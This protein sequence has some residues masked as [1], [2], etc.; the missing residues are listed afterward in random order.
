MSDHR[1]FPEVADGRPSL[2]MEPELWAAGLSLTDA[3]F[4][5]RQLAQNGYVLIEA[6]ALEH[7]RTEN[8]WLRAEN[9]S[10]RLLLQSIIDLGGTMGSNLYAD[11]VDRAC[12][13]ALKTKGQDDE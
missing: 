9:Q 1:S 13:A 3:R 2:P 8:E 11:T 12:R 4:V 7:L 5:A 10:Y 6:A